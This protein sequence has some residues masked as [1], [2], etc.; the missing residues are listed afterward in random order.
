MESPGKNRMAMI[1]STAIA[2]IGLTGVA[3]WIFNISFLQN[4]IPASDLLKV[5]CFALICLI[6]VWDMLNRLNDGR[7]SHLE[8][9]AELKE[10]NMELVKRVESRSAAVLRSEAKYRSLIEQASDAIYVL[11]F[12]NNFIDVNARMCEM[13]G[14]TREDLLALHITDIVDPEELKT[15]PLLMNIAETSVIRERRFVRKDGSIFNVEI[16]VK[17]FSDDRI[18]VIARDITDRKRMQAEL[19][20]TELK[21]RTIAEKSMLGVYIVQNG[22]FTYVNPRFAEI[23]GFGPG[24]LLNI[25]D[26]AAMIFHE[27]HLDVVREHVR[28]RIEGQLE[29]IRY[30]A[31]GKRKDGTANWVEIYGN[32]VMIGDTPAIIGSLLDITVRK[33][34]ADLI[35]EEKALSDSII[36]TLPGVF[37]LYNDK[38]EFLRWN[39][40]FETVTGYS[41]DEIRK[42]RVQSM[43]APED[44]ESVEKAIEKVF[45]EG[46]ATIEARAITKYGEKIPFLFTGTPIMY[47]NQQCLM[48]TGVDIS[49][50]LKAE[51]ELRQ[52][53]QKYKLLFES[54]PLPLWMIAK[55]DLSI[56]TG[57]EAAARLYG[58][59]KDE[60]LNMNVRQLRPPEDAEIQLE[61]YKK[62][63][64]S[65]S[66]MGIVRHLKKDG[67]IMQVQ[68]IAH[69]IILEDRPVRLSLTHDVTE[70]LIAE[71]QLQKSQANLQ[72]ILKT[73]NIAYALFDLDLTVLEF[74]Q[75]AIEFVKQHYYHAPKKGDRLMDFFPVD[76]GPQFISFTKS[77]LKGDHINYEVDYPQDEGATLW[78]AVSLFPITNDSK[79]ILGIM[80]AL[81][82]ITERK[83][84]EQDLQNAYLQIQIQVN[85]IKEMA[86]KQSHLLRSPL[87]NLKG[88]AA[89]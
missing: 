21:F 33:E 49:S 77:V 82:D 6:F 59:T 53:E 81:Y 52:S 25:E 87:A 62:D 89:M 24:E 23:F 83:N 80:M 63:I 48:G 55:D 71:E 13:T 27:S 37:Y 3:A 26:A 75:K 56:I 43:I 60:L 32:R 19:I 73:T 15:D 35:M 2:V 68:I 5:M 4:L 36:N 38:F 66:D 41:P 40:S 34:S 11:N 20:E 9:E 84:A 51:E 12:E 1:T 28:K 16:N 76:R 8:V 70:K 47:E 72:T 67:S 31:R 74:N 10:M 61:R 86:W 57:N 79:E 29:S 44:L 42:T 7:D 69:D 65:S 17:M 85:S 39:K 22:V 30:E 54:N 50:R 88:L 58:Y 18:F 78:Y 14:Y 64:T 46:Y 45:S